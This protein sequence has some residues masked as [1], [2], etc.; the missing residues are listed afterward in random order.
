MPPHRPEKLIRDRIPALARSQGRA[1]Q[2]RTADSAEMAR[3]LGLKLVEETHEVL[4]AVASEH[5]EAVLDELADLQ[6]VIE[7]IGSRFGLSPEVV[8]ERARA[9]RAERGGFEQGLVLALP[10]PTSRRLHTGGSTSLLD[11]LK[12]EFEACRRARIAVAFVMDSGLDLL[13][14]AA[15]AALLR[16]AEIQFLTTDY[17]GVTEPT[18]L[19]RLLK[20]H[21][22]L[23]ARVFSHPRRSFHPKAYLFERTD[24]SGR[25]FIGSANLSRMGLTEGVEWTWTVMDV[26]AGHPMH[27]L[28]TRFEELFVAPDTAELSPQWIDSY[29]ERRVIPQAETALQVRD[30]LSAKPWESESPVEPRP[31]QQLALDELHKLRLDGQTK[32]L[33][34]AATG[35]G[36]TYLAAFD[37]RGF[38][39]VLFV[40]HRQELL[41]QAQAAFAKVHPGK[42]CGL[43]AGG[44]LELDRDLV[45][46]SIQTLT[47][48][49]TLSRPEL[50]AFD[51]VV[52]DEFHHAAADSYRKLLERLQ[53]KF[54]LGLTATPFRG[55]N[56]DLLELCG[57]NLAYQVGLFEAITF[58]WLTP[59]R[60]H[61]VADVVDYTPDLLNAQRTG[62]DSAKLTLTF[63]TVERSALAIRH[64][65]THAGVATLGFCVSIEH[66]EFMAARFNEAG[67]A[68]A[69]VHSGPASLN[70]STAIAQ[71]SSGGLKVLFTVDLFN[72]G[73]DIP[74]VDV[75]MFLRPTESV[76]IFLQQL[77]RGLR[78]HP[79]K[80][81]LTVLD[82][83]GNYRNAHY[84]LP[85]LVGLEP[86][87][88]ADPTKA[89]AALTAWQTQGR[90]P[91]TVPA[92]VEI[93]LEPVALSTLRASFAQASPLRDLIVQELKELALSQGRVPTLQEWQ[94]WSRYSLRTARQALRVPRW[95]GVLREAD[96]LSETEVAL[97][98]VVGSFLQEVETTSMTKSFKMV[99]LLAFCGP[100]SPVFRRSVHIAELVATFRAYFSAERHRGDVVRTDVE[101]VQACSHETWARY[102]KRN[103]IQAW[104]GGNTDTT[105]PWFQW[106]E[107]NQV[108]HYV[109][110]YPSEAALQHTMS[111]AVWDRAQA[112]LDGYWDRPGPHS[113]LYK[114]IPA[115]SGGK[116][117]IMF[118]DGRG[119]LPEGW[120]LAEINGRRLYGKF[121]KVALNVLK[122]RPNDSAEWPNIL[123]EELQKLLGA[124]IP[125][126]SRVRLVKDVGAAV[127]RILAA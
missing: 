87:Q 65:R 37:A 2:V 52:I 8:Q 1:L 48:P 53:P 89:L 64:Y 46:A 19:Q 14:G 113:G 60:Y 34:V 23:Q 31:V 102:L 55:D 20:W 57:G 88:D 123:T 73:V 100:Q 97:D 118:G 90:R 94:R 112:R 50:D 77:G 76:T 3:L 40:A 10:P 71:L 120:H 111:M 66:A 68:S 45:F 104:C 54:L 82:F 16:G 41:T 22:H 32:A 28:T 26:D 17:L 18:A 9:K 35:L 59:F 30:P 79:N 39:R 103:P 72:E 81:H 56:R 29:L 61:G 12:R 98:E 27:E 85:L 105:S 63:N 74:C 127:W 106:N 4:Q 93:H 38:D 21:G 114:V 6:T 84:K 69:A 91:D 124:S 116:V 51:Y 107:S 78:L 109:G 49:S 44:Q 122:E 110:P 92:G 42:S 62:Y 70:R 43:A 99:V 7:T 11:A 75:V 5:R 95:S 121:V 83:I 126:G 96:Q 80:S 24:G 25:A 33:V 13:E 47:Q 86:T 58:G 15:L 125:Q 108:L 36:K 119:N 67:I 115:G 117:C 101:D